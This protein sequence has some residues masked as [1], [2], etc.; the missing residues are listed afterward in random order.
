ML[1]YSARELQKGLNTATEYVSIMERAQ[2]YAECVVDSL[3]A[4]QSEQ[5]VCLFISSW[6]SLGRYQAAVY[7]QAY[8]DVRR[9]SETGDR[10]MVFSS[11][12]AAETERALCLQHQVD[13]AEQCC[14][15]QKGLILAEYWGNRVI[16]ATPAAVAKTPATAKATG[17]ESAIE[18]DAAS[19]VR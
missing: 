9:I 10:L 12:A 1:K 7:K 14:A 13:M 15:S 6:E 17:T 3:A 11:S 4:V 19:S 16:R 18:I 8:K 2:E 5:M